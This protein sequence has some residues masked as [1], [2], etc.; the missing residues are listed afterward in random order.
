MKKREIELLAPAGS[1]ESLISAVQN[2]A[3]AVYIGG[4][5]FN[6]RMNANNFD[7][8]TMIAAID[9]AHLRG[10]KIFVTMNTLIKDEELIEALKYAKFIY[11]AG[12][13]ALIIQDL[14]FGSLVMENLPD[15]E[16]HLSTQATISDRKS[17]EVAK[18]L[19]Y[20]RIV[21]SRELSL[22]EIKDISDIDDV[23]IEVFVHGAICVSYSGQ[24]QLS[25]RYGGRSGNRGT[26]AQ[27]CRLPYI[28]KIV[29]STSTINTANR[30]KT[31]NT[32]NTTN[33]TKITN[34]A[35]KVNAT[36]TTK[37]TRENGEK[38]LYALSP[39]D[40]C[41]VKNLGELIEAGV[42]SFKIEGRMK[43]PEYVGVITRI[44][45][46]YIDLY[47][48]NGEY[49]ITE[50]DREALSQIF[51]R[52][53][54][55]EGFLHKDEGS[56]F[57]S[58]T[59]PKNNGIYAG[60]VNFSKKGSKLIKINSK[61]GLSLHDGLEIRKENGEIISSGIITYLKKEADGSY[62]I[63]DFK[64]NI[65]AGHHAYRTSQVEQ[66]DEIR[67]T[68]KDI[69]IFDRDDKKY[70]KKLAIKLIIISANG[71]L[72]L[73][74]DAGNG[75]I[76]KVSRKILISDEEPSSIDKFKKSLI[77]TGNTSFAISNIDFKG[78][79]NIK[80]K[81]SE[82]NELRRECLNKLSKKL[83][84]RRK[85]PDINFDD[86]ILKKNLSKE[87]DEVNYKKFKLFYT[88]DEYLKFREKGENSNGN[89]NEYTMLL[90]LADLCITNIDVNLDI[91]EEYLPYIS[92][93]TRGKENMILEE[94][95]SKCLKICKKRGV[96]VGNL[97]WLKRF[98]GDNIKVIADY[99]LNSYNLE[100]EKVLK[101]LGAF[102]VV[103]SLEAGDRDDMNY[104]LMVTE[105]NFEYEDLKSEYSHNLKIVKRPY[106]S[107]DIIIGK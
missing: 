10:V 76:S 105:H 23:D 37:T 28:A 83:C 19:G 102:S 12:A 9:Y 62:L 35:N 4:K 77:K 20:K 3:D 71:L 93:V 86:L 45:R 101:G 38:K 15:F 40:L 17:L 103:K 39:R 100:T 89:Q 95:Y 79:F 65:K 2:G 67:K 104:P 6:A 81:I 21:L 41:Q 96:L 47:L 48:K 91:E 57:M 94:N 90:P 107:Q 60:D 80:I 7:D 26:C 78:D 98:S 59:I 56:K 92:A 55:T 49:K 29:K 32:T 34:K 44:Y 51:N 27:A 64:G 68:F 36:N 82:I 53:D 69:D 75:I 42:K 73:I 97:G 85:A 43:S 58:N 46:K 87:K 50:E 22:D 84:I 61:L 74:A 1:V 24:C 72:T 33:I 99:G 70:N 52:G 18:G 13:D 63:G 5:L 106:S 31:N 66:I 54:F 30:T 16:L 88:I 25:R 14:G 8:K 11:E